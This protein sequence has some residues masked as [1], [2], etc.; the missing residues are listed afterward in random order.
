MNY[1]QD[2]FLHVSIFGVVDMGR[3]MEM[4]WEEAMGREIGVG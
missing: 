3:Y 2:Q 4:R 1:I